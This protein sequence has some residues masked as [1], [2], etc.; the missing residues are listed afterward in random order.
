V[1]LLAKITGEVLGL[2]RDLFFAHPYFDW[3]PPLSKLSNA[4]LFRYAMTGYIVALRCLKE[5]GQNGVSAKNIGSQII[6]ATI[7]AY[8][9]YFDGF[10][11][12][13]GR[14]QQVYDSARDQ[15]LSSKHATFRGGP[16]G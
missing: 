15:G 14:A 4:F 9:T 13:D 3:P 7:A 11:S 8:A 2:A 10:L 6:D 12:D 5:G 16:P 1:D